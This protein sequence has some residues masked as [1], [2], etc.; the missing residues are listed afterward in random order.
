M[1]SYVERNGSIL[2]QV[3]IQRDGRKAFS[4]SKTFRT[5]AAATLWAER[6]QLKAS[7]AIESAVDNISNGQL[8]DERELMSLRDR[9]LSV[10]AMETRIGDIAELCRMLAAATP[11]RSGPGVYMLLDSGGRVVYVGQSASVA[12]RLVGHEGKAYSDVRMIHEPD[13]DR[14][15]SIESRLV[16][17]LDPPLNRT[18]R[19]ASV[20]AP[21]HTD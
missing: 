15:L 10:R 1:P 8:E 2:A 3:R 12:A 7:A 19:L 20:S 11:L 21:S 4:R 16:G 17:V 13:Q 9:E 6:E 14:R 5:L 18:L